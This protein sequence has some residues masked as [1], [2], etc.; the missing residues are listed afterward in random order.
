MPSFLFCVFVYLSAMHEMA[1]AASYE[2]CLG[3]YCGRTVDEYG[4]LS[5]CGVS[6]SSSLHVGNHRG[7]NS[8]EI[9]YVDPVLCFVSL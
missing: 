4:N 9:A 7:P 6:C 2:K 8:P 3:V 5:S 1:H